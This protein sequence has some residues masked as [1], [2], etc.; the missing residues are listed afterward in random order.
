LQS[1]LRKKCWR[2]LDGHNQLPKVILDAKLPYEIEVAALWRPPTSLKSPP[3]EPSGRHQ[4][5]A[6]APV[7]STQR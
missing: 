7:A 2:R 3:P 4:N 1:V 6:M 5:S